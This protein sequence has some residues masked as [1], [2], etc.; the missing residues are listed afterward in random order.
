[1]AFPSRKT[2]STARWSIAQWIGVVLL[3]AMLPGGATALSESSSDPETR[4]AWAAAAEVIETVESSRRGIRRAAFSTEAT[5]RNWP[6]SPSTNARFEADLRPASDDAATLIF[7]AS[8]G[9]AVRLVIVPGGPDLPPVTKTL[10]TTAEELTPL[11]AELRGLA[12]LRPRASLGRIVRLGDELGR[13]L[14]PP[15]AD[16]LRGTSRVVLLANG[17]LV[18]L[19]FGAI[20]APRSIDPQG[21][22][23]V[24]TREL[25]WLTPGGNHRQAATDGGRS[26]QPPVAAA[27]ADAVYRPPARPL[28]ASMS[29]G[30]I[31][32]RRHAARRNQSHTL[33]EL[34]LTNVT[35]FG[36]AAT[37]AAL[38]KLSARHRIEVLH[39]AVEAI[40]DVGAPTASALLLSARRY[41][42]PARRVMVGA[43]ASDLELGR[44]PVVVLSGLD[45]GGSGLGPS[46]FV[47]AFDAAGAKTVVSS[48][49]PVV[50]ETATKLFEAFY[51]HLALGA[52]PSTALREAQLTLLAAPLRFDQGEGHESME[53]DASHPFYWAGY[54]VHQ[55]SAAACSRSAALD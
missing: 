13:R 45:S 54:G 42:Q 55:R 4:T 10:D 53:F 32:W 30:G 16:Q 3:G 34:A 41:D 22:F 21:R 6:P 36:Q 49:W 19:P 25:C 27:I 44:D 14:L 8:P 40:V 47:D 52:P 18:E 46:P 26:R 9:R 24:E 17:P 12:L 1:M 35:A 5:T 11:I 15:A 33:E 39:L 50:D 2:N 43:L 48:L 20:R 29:D 38:W 28:G 37:P 23:L 51:R 7:D 31:S